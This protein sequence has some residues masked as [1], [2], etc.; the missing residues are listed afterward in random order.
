[1]ENLEFKIP[2]YA[3]I[4]DLLQEIGLDLIVIYLYTLKKCDLTIF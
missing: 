4:N 2:Y 1:M 3:E